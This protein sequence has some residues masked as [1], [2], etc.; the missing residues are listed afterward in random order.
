LHFSSNSV[1]GAES[2][3][4]QPDPSPQSPLPT[5][6]DEDLASFLDEI[7][8]KFPATPYNKPALKT[9]TKTRVKSA[10]IGKSIIDQ[11]TNITT[12]AANITSQAAK[13]V[14]T[15]AAKSPGRVMSALKGGLS[16]KRDKSEA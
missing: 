9:K 13:T 10:Q 16:L 8:P 12:Q 6:S 14:A 7:I 11:A 4:V 1:S 5:I 15:Q 3:S 2:L